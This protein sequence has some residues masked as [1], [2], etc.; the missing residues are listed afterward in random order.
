[1]SKLKLLWDAALQLLNETYESVDE[2]RTELVEQAKHDAVRRAREQQL[3]S[4]TLAS[5]PF[6][7]AIRR[8]AQAIEKLRAKAYKEGQQVLADLL[9]LEAAEKT[10]D[11]LQQAEV[12]H[13]RANS[14]NGNPA[15]YKE[16]EDLVAALFQRGVNRHT[17]KQLS[18]LETSFIADL[19]RWKA[20]S[21]RHV[22]EGSPWPALFTAYKRRILEVHEPGDSAPS[23]SKPGVAPPSKNH[24][25]RYWHYDAVYGWSNGLRNGADYLRKSSDNDLTS[26]KAATS[27][28]PHSPT[29]SSDVISVEPEAAQPQTTEPPPEPDVIPATPNLE[30][31]WPRSGYQ[32]ARTAV[33]E[34]AAAQPQQIDEHEALATAA[35]MFAEADYHNSFDQILIEAAENEDAQASIAFLKRLPAKIGDS[36]DIKKFAERIG[37]VGYRQAFEEFRTETTQRIA[38]SLVRGNRQNLIHALKVRKN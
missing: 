9:A 31:S 3:S 15:T 18:R 36:V 14:H 13:T 11:A 10:F 20:A 4:P 7:E 35:K 17:V 37:V 32:N 38:R 8:Q 16:W 2:K 6:P 27:E 29:D 21:P 25:T 24:G 23:L 26:E 30:R 22:D 5:T 1:M 28:L 19:M 34:L 33:Q 12:R